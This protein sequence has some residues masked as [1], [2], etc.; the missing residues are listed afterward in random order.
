ML[1]SYSLYAYMP[2]RWK[3]TTCT[4]T[5]FMYIS[6]TTTEGKCLL[7]QQK[8][9]SNTGKTDYFNNGK[10]NVRIRGHFFCMYVPNDWAIA[11]VISL[12][13][14]GILLLTKNIALA[15]FCR[16]WHPPQTSCCV[17]VKRLSLSDGAAS[18]YKHI[19]AP[20]SGHNRERERGVEKES[21]L[22]PGRQMIKGDRG[23]SQE[24][25]QEWLESKQCRLTQ[26]QAILN[27][28]EK[29]PF[30]SRFI[31]NQTMLARL[32]SKRQPHSGSSKVTP[33]MTQ[34][35]KNPGGGKSLSSHFGLLAL[36][37]VR[38]RQKTTAK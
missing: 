5:L 13:I 18:S 15:R 33:P 7:E 10:G 34:K 8:S 32:N 31:K 3:Y 35:I 14:V 21:Q 6:L 22:S 11:I 23:E 1:C 29:P 30:Y 9:R 17:C 38:T 4:S 19:S 26:G 16:T 12:D 20:Q 36:Y 37:R 24:C 25:P 27:L 28:I 2:T